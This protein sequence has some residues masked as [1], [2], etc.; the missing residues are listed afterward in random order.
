MKYQIQRAIKTENGIVN[1]GDL[2]YV[3]M[4]DKTT[5]TCILEDIY[6]KD[7]Y[8]AIMY[9][10]KEKIDLEDVSLIMNLGVV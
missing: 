4:K 10:D 8:N 1:L 6:W 7:E 5:I 9:T 2:I 3:V